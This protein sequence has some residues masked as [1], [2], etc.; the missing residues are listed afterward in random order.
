MVIDSIPFEPGFSICF[1]FSFFKPD[2][3]YIISFA[4]KIS[5]DY[6]HCLCFC[7]FSITNSGVNRKPGILE[8]I[9]ENLSQSYDLRPASS[10]S[11]S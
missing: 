8:E 9:T 5:R 1:F 6:F 11:I 7:K 10:G 4:A 3:P 2:A